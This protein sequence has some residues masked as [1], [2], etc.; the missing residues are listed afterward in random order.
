MCA[1]WTDACPNP[2]VARCTLKAEALHCLIRTLLCGNLSIFL[3]YFLIYFCNSV[4]SYINAVFWVLIH[5]IFMYVDNFFQCNQLALLP[6]RHIP[7][8]VSILRTFWLSANTQCSSSRY[9][10]GIESRELGVKWA[11]CHWGVIVTGI[12]QLTK[13][14]RAWVCTNLGNRLSPETVLPTGF[15]MYTGWTLVHTD[16]P[17]LNHMDQLMLSFAQ[18]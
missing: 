17:D 8:I 1:L 2:G 4:E 18:L 10:N 6:L 3:V 9:F 15:C 12:P 14:G 5:Y 13:Q 7:I 16:L 11:Y